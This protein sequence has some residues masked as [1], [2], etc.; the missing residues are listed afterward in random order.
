MFFHH[1]NNL[2]PQIKFTMEREENG[3]LPFLDTLIKRNADKSISVSV[4]RKP[5]H[6]DQYLNFQSN[7]QDS[8]K[9]S[10]ISSLL[11]RAENIVSNED[12]KIA[13]KQRV[14]SVLHANNYSKR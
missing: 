12:D 13:E 8:A 1:V 4:Y 11:S 14:I 7:H 6:T 9:E 5:T 2:H 10:V 3:C